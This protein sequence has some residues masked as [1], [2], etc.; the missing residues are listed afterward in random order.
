MASAQFGLEISK[1]ESP[2]LT[3]VLIW[4]EV[5]VAGTMLPIL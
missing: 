2:L 3:N 5:A 1:Q 4:L